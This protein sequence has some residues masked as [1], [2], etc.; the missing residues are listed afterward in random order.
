[1]LRIVG[2]GL[3]TYGAALLWLLLPLGRHEPWAAWAALTV[4]LTAVTPV[5]YV[6]IALRRFKPS[7]RT[8][9]VPATV[10][11]VLAVAGAVL[12]LAA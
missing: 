9:V 10:V 12:S 7:A 8:P 5:L 6:T 3:L 2:G 4:T 11:L 1:M